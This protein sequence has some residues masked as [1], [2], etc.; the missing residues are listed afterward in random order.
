MA[1]LNKKYKKIING[2]CF[3]PFALLGTHSDDA[4]YWE[5]TTFQPVAESVWV[6]LKGRKDPLSMKKI[7]Q[8]GIF[9][10][11]IKRKAKPE[12][13]FDV[14]GFDGS[15]WREEDPYSFLPILTEYD[16]YLF[17]EGNH[18]RIF[19]KLGS[20]IME[21]E[22]KSGVHFAVWA[23]N[24][25]RVS[26]VGDF[27]SWD[28]RRHQM[29]V[30]GSSGVWEIFLPGLGEGEKY[31]YEIRTQSGDILTKADPYGH[32]MEKRPKTASIVYPIGRYQ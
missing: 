16:L 8:D 9:S 24:A 28:G 32:F 13:S 30:M 19:E 12:Y 11:K 7:I 17:N 4:G 1:D 20:H 22:G 18:F 6:V 3:N 21:S 25:Q 10:I 23:P 5:I 2:T 26:V 15:M 14:K 27:N 29:R 31:K